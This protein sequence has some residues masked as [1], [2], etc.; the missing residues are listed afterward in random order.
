MSFGEL[1]GKVIPE[2]GSTLKYSGESCG[3]TQH[4]SD[5]VRDAL[6]GTEFDTLINGEITSETGLFV[7]NNCLVVSGYALN[8]NALA[9]KGTN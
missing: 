2:S 9:K 6:K 8:S 4:L 7:W 1:E 3:E 5:A